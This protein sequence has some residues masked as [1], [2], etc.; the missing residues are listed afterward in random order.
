MA[1]LD[2]PAVEVVVVDNGA[3]EGR[4]GQIRAHFPDVTLIETGR[5]LGFAGGCNLGITT[6]VE[7]LPYLFFGLP[8][9]AWVDRVDRKRLML[10]VDAPSATVIGGIPA[11]ARL[12]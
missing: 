12:G 7:M 4:P 2:Y 3:P 11:A 1:K 5:N 10:D 6:A 8:I 9:R